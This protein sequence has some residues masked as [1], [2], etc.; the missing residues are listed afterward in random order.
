MNFSAF[1]HAKMVWKCVSHCQSY[2][3]SSA[4]TEN[5]LWS[6]AP[7]QKYL[8]GRR[9][10]TTT[11]LAACVVWILFCVVWGRCYLGFFAHA[12]LARVLA[13]APCLSSQIES[14]ETDERIE[15]VLG[16]GSSF[17]LSY[18]VLEGNSGISRDNG[19]SLWKSKLRT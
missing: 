13:I 17:H 12:M 6:A 15:L 3:H 9:F 4:D 5:I 19:T 2:V 8:W 10:H 1:W 11:P 18:T 16:V 14:V 7:H